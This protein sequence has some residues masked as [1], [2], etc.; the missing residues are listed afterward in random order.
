M[1]I[2]RVRRDGETIYGALEGDTVRALQG[3]VFEN[4]T[5]GDAI[6]SVDELELLAPVEP[7]KI[8]AIGL[9]YRDHVVEDAGREIPENPVIFLKPTS[10]VIGPD[11]TIVLPRESQK[12]D[13]E[14]E[15]AIV[16]GKRCRNVPRAQAADAVLGYTAS[17]DVSAR[18][19]Q[20]ADG[21]W[22]RAK[23]YDTFAPIG[24]AIATDVDPSDLAINSRVNGE[25]FQSSSTKHLIFD[26]PFLVEF[27]S[28]VMTLEPGDVIMTGTPAGPPQLHDGDTCEVEIAGIGVLRNPVKLAE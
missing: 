5:L 9:N 10:A 22:V 12:I 16:I 20:R 6:G 1:Q 19:F 26:V 14:A 28:R 13:A 2:V 25:G 18:D 23:G 11:A 24:P 21:Q 15:L 7:G 27:V 17:N 8:V 3:D 4:P